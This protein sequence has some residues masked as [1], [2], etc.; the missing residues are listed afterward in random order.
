[1]SIASVRETYVM[2]TE[3]HY[4]GPTKAAGFAWRDDFGCI[5]F[6]APRARGVPHR[7]LEVVRWCLLGEKNGGSRQWARAADMIRKQR[8]DCTTVVSYSDPGQGH[9]G[10]LY[11]SCNWL[12][13][14][15]WHRLRPPPSGNGAWTDDKE[16]GVK[17]R[18]VYLLKPDVGREQVLS[19]KDESI[20][21]LMPWAGY[22]EPA[23]RHGRFDP[24]ERSKAY[25]QFISR[26][27]AA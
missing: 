18:W 13:A 27:A 4:L 5:V 21:R 11:R 22:R 10:A 9:T 25:K 6:A 7:W 19:V 17:D 26:G 23:W 12:W 14:P 1:M 3:R 15:T 8:P 16:Q 2:L 20:S 24:S